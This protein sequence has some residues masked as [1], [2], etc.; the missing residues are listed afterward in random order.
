MTFLSRCFF[1][2]FITTSN[3]QRAEQEKTA[4]VSFHWRC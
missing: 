1:F 4:T 2:I 3:L